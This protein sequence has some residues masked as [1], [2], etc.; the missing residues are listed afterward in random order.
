MRQYVE[1]Y[2][3]GEKIEEVIK[4]GEYN[5]SGLT[6]SF[7]IKIYKDDGKNTRSSDYFSIIEYIRNNTR[8]KVPKI[9]QYGSFLVGNMRYEY[10]VSERIYGVCLRDFNGDKEKVLGTVERYKSKMSIKYFESMG[11]I[12]YQNNGSYHIIE[13]FP[14][15]ENYKKYPERIIRSKT[16]AFLTTLDNIFENCGS[17]EFFRKYSTTQVKREVNGTIE[18]TRYKISLQHRNIN[19]DTIIISNEDDVFLVGWKNTAIYPMYFEDDNTKETVDRIVLL[20]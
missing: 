10:V 1:K 8:V 14:G 2:V 4:D 16:N 12:Y 6:K 20:E 7:Y 13:E 17:L 18:N 3:Q 11:K 9:L 5:F 19:D 15:I